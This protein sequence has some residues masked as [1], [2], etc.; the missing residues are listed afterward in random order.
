MR[1][2]SLFLLTIVLA[3]AG[4]ASSGGG[5]NGPTSLTAIKAEMIVQGHL[6]DF[7]DESR[8]DGKTAAQVLESYR[9]RGSQTTS[10]SIPEALI[11]AIVT[12]ESE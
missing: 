1:G 7:S 2:K 8:I 3:I 5:A 12:G 11:E 10:R 9:K 4:C 6:G